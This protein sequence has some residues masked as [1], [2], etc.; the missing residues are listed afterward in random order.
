MTQRPKKK[1]DTKTTTATLPTASELAGQLGITLEPTLKA[2]EVHRLRKALPGYAGLLDDV[3]ELLAHDAGG[4]NFAEASPEHL[5]ELQRKHKELRAREAVL[6]SVY[7]SV[8]HQRLRIDDEAMGLLQKLARRVH[9]R[10][11]EDPH[12]VARW[13]LLLDFLGTFRQGRR[14]AKEEAPVSTPPPPAAEA[15][16]TS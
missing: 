10:A 1:N 6:E 8:F 14:P 15:A 16:T 7:G 4:L 3:A 11:E 2:N 12:L 5:L 9:S 13:Q